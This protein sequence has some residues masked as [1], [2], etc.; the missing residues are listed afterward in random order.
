MQ[1]RGEV[2]GAGSI[3]PGKKT[4]HRLLRWEER[5]EGQV[6]AR[7]TGAG[8]PCGR[9]WTRRAD[10][11]RTAARQPSDGRHGAGPNARLPLVPPASG[12]VSAAVSAS[13]TYFSS[14][15]TAFQTVA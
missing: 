7:G 12:G 9:V 4:E 14:C 6:R 13:S 5:A 15:L 11:H 8:R 3:L 1:L 10:T 2:W